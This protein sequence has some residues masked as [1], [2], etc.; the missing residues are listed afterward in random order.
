MTLTIL[1]LIVDSF[2]VFFSFT[3][4]YSRQRHISPISLEKR[5][6]GLHSHSLGSN[7]LNVSIDILTSI[8]PVIGETRDFYEIVTGE[9]FLSGEHLHLFDILL[10]CISL[11]FNFYLFVWLQRKKFIENLRLVWAGDT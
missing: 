2:L 11:C 9:D 5:Q 8:L 10:D 3:F 1:S 6:Q 7:P 4:N